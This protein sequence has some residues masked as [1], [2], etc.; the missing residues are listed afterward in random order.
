MT[1]TGSGAFASLKVT[2]GQTKN[3]VNQA[4]DITWSGAGT[5]APG[6][7]FG[8]NFLQIMQCWGDD[9]AGPT[10]EQCQYGGLAATDQRGGTF[11]STR[12][13]N[14][15]SL[16]DPKEKLPAGAGGDQVFVPFT[17]VT[18][19]TTQG[20][21]NEFYDANTTN[22]I[23]FARTRGDGTRLRAVRGPDRPRVAR[24]SAAGSP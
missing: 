11:V 4:V 23:A 20:N 8:V 14:Y 6:T 13:L 16:V 10:R 2:V 24:G 7:G 5:T 18:G 19:V 1:V 22:E 21:F 12:Q 17:S 9:A 3:L 15:G